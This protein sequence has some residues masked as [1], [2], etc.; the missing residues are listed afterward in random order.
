MFF[1]LQGEEQG[2]DTGFDSPSPPPHR[3][4]DDC[5]SCRLFR[6]SYAALETA[7]ERMEMLAAEL[8]T[9]ERKRDAWAEIATSRLVIGEV[10]RSLHSLS[11]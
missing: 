8:S 11:G 1:F 2:G 4:G 10:L 6:Q 9:D 7:I 5:A 3:R